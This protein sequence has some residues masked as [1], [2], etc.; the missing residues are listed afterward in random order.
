MKPEMPGDDFNITSFGD[1]LKLGFIGLAGVALVMGV[2]MFDA[3]NKRRLDKNG[4][5][6][7][8]A[9]LIGGL[10]VC[11]MG[12]SW[13]LIHEDNEQKIAEIKNTSDRQVQDAKRDADAKVQEI[14]NATDRQVQNA[15]RD[16]DAELQKML[17]SFASC[18]DR[19]KG[20]EGYIAQLQ[21]ILGQRD[22]LAQQVTALNNIR[23]NLQKTDEII[24][25]AIKERIA[26]ANGTPAH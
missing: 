25:N 9:F 5:R 8:I 11:G 23:E 24:K 4:F 12:L 21:V 6:L 7:A 18:A 3:A 16:A 15:K 17:A 22:H 10:I 20:K 26:S 1:W 2:R 14:K 13:S 19:L